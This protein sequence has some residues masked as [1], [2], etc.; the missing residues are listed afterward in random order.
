MINSA[1]AYYTLPI[2]PYRE[3]FRVQPFQLPLSSVSQGDN[4]LFSPPTKTTPTQISTPTL[5]AHDK[6]AWIGYFASGCLGGIGMW[7]LSKF[8]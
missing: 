7:L 8:K 6:N 4:A 2:S 3:S 1:S 5:S